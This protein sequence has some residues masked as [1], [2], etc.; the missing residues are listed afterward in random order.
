MWEFLA[1]SGFNYQLKMFITTETQ[2][3]ES[4]NDNVGIQNFVL[5]TQKWLQESL[6]EDM[7]HTHVPVFE[8]NTKKILK[9]E[10]LALIF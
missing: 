3:E 8:E 10:M 4:R 7:V 9:K 6:W 2:E 5:G 1:P